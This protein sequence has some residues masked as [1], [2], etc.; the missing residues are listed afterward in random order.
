VNRD[1]NYIRRVTFNLGRVAVKTATS[2]LLA[3]SL[4]G[5]QPPDGAA[6]QKVMGFVDREGGRFFQEWS[7][8]L[9]AEEECGGR[10]CFY[11]PRL[12]P[13]TRGQQLQREDLFEVAKP[14][15]SWA[16][17]ASFIA[18]PHVDKN[19]GATVLCYRSYFP[20]TSS[21]VY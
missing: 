7:G 11:Y 1:P 5:G 20:A 15:R 10:V 8:L 13:A 4:L 16:L 9:V 17:H 3:Q 12:S 18:L 6:I 2:L 19:D 14:L 21:A